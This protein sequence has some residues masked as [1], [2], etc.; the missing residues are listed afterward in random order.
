MLPQI[1]DI[2]SDTNMLYGLAG[3]ERAVTESPVTQRMTEKVLEILLPQSLEL[4]LPLI[5]VAV[6]RSVIA[7]TTSARFCADPTEQDGV[8]MQTI[9][10]R[11]KTRV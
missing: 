2:N 11:K 3:L 5:A 1:P 7:T 9:A 8:S 10:A 6:E 4:D